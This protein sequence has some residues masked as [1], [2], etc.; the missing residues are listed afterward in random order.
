MPSFSSPAAPA[1]CRRRRHAL[2]GPPPVWGLCTL[3][4]VSQEFTGGVCGGGGEAVGAGGG[5]PSLPTNFQRTLGS[6]C[7]HSFLPSVFPSLLLFMPSAWIAFP[8]RKLLL[9]HKYKERGDSHD[10]FEGLS[11]FSLPAHF[12]SPGG[13]AHETPAGTASLQ[14]RK[15][16]PRRSEGIGPNVS[17]CASRPPSSCWGPLGLSPGPSFHISRGTECTVSIFSDP[18]SHFPFSS[19]SY[20]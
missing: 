13:R 14:G 1:Q 12:L 8:I 15:R 11:C 9:C 3:S 7:S 16:G 19:F 6:L 10:S 20:F 2:G 5:G 4:Q 18:G 17:L